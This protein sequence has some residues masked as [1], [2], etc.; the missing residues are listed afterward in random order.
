MT[1]EVGQLAAPGRPS[2]EIGKNW[3]LVAAGYLRYQV[4]F[5][6]QYSR[7]ALDMVSLASYYRA[8]DIGCGPGTMTVPLAQRVSHAVAVDISE[9]MLRCL[10]RRQ[11]G[12]GGGAF[13]CCRSDARSLPL[14]DGVFDVGFSMFGIGTFTGTEEGV[15]E[16]FRILKPG[17]IGLI[18]VWGEPKPLDAPVA[19]ARALHQ[20]VGWLPSVFKPTPAEAMCQIMA[21]VGFVRMVRNIFSATRRMR[22]IEELWAVNLAA[23]AEIA[24]IR[25]TCGTG[26]EGVSQLFLQALRRQTLV[27]PIETR[28]PAQFIVGRKPL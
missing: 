17:G 8:V 12:M 3:D 9:E 18:A 28:W 19:V 26:F 2:I 10:Y 16:L 4:P 15:R 24:A 7:A 11:S 21:K 27:L 14:G 5:L 13:S 1:D 23:S 20:A 22:S 25:R 6:E